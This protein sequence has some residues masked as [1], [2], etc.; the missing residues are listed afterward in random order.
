MTTLHVIRSYLTNRKQSIR[1]S[2]LDLFIGVPQGS[3]IGSLFFNIYLNDLMLDFSDNDGGICNY[4]DDNTLY[5]SS[6]D[7][8]KVKQKLEKAL[9]FVSEWFS[10]NGLQLNADKCQLIVFGKARLSPVLITFNGN[11]LRECSNVT[12]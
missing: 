5:A 11:V 6:T 1:N 8:T 9:F 12:L 3:V 2:W 10:R 7:I 4:T